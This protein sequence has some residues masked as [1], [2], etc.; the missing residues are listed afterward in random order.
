LNSF[1]LKIS[2]VEPAVQANGI[3]DLIVHIQGVLFDPRPREQMCSRI[4]K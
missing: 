1:G 3:A 2:G 4:Q